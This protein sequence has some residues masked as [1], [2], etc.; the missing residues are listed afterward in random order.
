MVPQRHRAKTPA[1]ISYAQVVP[2]SGIDHAPSDRRGHR[3]VAKACLPLPRPP[4]IRTAMSLRTPRIR[5]CPP[6]HRS[7][8]RVRR[9]APGPGHR[10]G[11]RQPTIE[12]VI[13]VSLSRLAATHGDPDDAFDFLTLAIRNYYDS[14]SFSLLR[15]PLAILAAFLDRLGHHEPAATISGFAA[16][17]ATRAGIPETRHDDRPSARGPRRR[18][19]RIACA[20]RAKHDQCAPWRLRVRPDRPGSRGACRRL[21]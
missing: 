7:R 12:S 6:R 13:A 14:G 17:P 16:N 3:S 11:Q 5:L 15:S 2:G 18:R 4:T 1:H 21:P 20:R 10:A 8:C 19:L 9:P